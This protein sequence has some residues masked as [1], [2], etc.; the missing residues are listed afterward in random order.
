VTGPRVALDLTVCKHDRAGSGVYAEHLGAA[1]QSLLGS[2]FIALSFPLA[3]PPRARAPFRRRLQTLTRDLWWAQWAVARTAQRRGADLLHLPVGVGPIRCSLPYVV[4]IHDLAVLRFPERFRI[5]FRNYSRFVLPRLAANAA[6]IIAVSEASRNDIIEYLDQ[7]PERVVAVPNGVA[8]GFGPRS[9]D[10]DETVA[11]R[12]RY[13]LQAD[14]ALTVGSVEPRKNLVRLLRA[15]SALRRDPATSDVQLVHV[16]PPGWL[17]RDVI[18]A[19]RE[20]GLESAVRFLGY[21]PTAELPTLYSLARLLVYPSLYEGFGL[22]VLEA[23]ACGCPVVTSNT[24]SLPEVAGSAAVLV[25]P[26]STDS[27]AEGLRRVWSDAALQAKLREMGLVRA[28]QFSW[29]RTARETVQVY[30]SVLESAGDRSRG[31]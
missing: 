7:S 16:G 20:L 26:T 29:Q 1:L 18:L 24:S 12:Q 4:T 17:N 22:P 13:G 23:M 8:P 30:H 10:L 3:S 25:D 11:V 28:G 6:K 15:V 5:W 27:I 2:E 19:H 9:R 14:F 31:R 21:V